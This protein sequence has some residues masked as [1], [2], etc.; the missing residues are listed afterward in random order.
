MKLDALF[1]TTGL[2]LDTK[3]F[4]HER[5]LDEKYRSGMDNC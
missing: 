1:Y 5:Q 3:T 2:W 4:K